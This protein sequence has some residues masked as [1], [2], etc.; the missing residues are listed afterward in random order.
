M[1]AS[2]KLGENASD[3]VAPAGDDRKRASAGRAKLGRLCCGVILRIPGF[4]KAGALE[5]H[6]GVGVSE[7]KNSGISPKKFGTGQA[8]GESQGGAFAREGAWREAR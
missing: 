1:F 8:C 5:G 4:V 7:E 3:V 2:P 6:G